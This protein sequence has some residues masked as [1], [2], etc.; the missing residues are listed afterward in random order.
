MMLG[1]DEMAI[2]RITSGI[3]NHTTARAPPVSSDALA[4]TP[5]A[6]WRAGAAVGS[7]LFTG[8][9]SV[10]ASVSVTAVMSST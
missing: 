8:T 7:W 1:I 4:A 9:R 5:S 6:L 2:T 10:T 3:Q